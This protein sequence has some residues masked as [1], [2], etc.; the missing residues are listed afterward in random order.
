LTHIKDISVEELIAIPLNF[1]ESEEFQNNLRTKLTFQPLTKIGIENIDP[2]FQER[3]KVLSEAILSIYFDNEENIEYTESWNYTRKSLELLGESI[4]LEKPI[5]NDNEELIVNDSSPVLPAI[6]FKK[7]PSEDPKL[8]NAYEIKNEFLLSY[9]DETKVENDILVELKKEIEKNG[10]DFNSFLERFN[11]SL[12]REIF[13]ANDESFN[14]LPVINDF[15]FVKDNNS[16]DT[17]I[18]DKKTV[19]DKLIR[20]YFNERQNEIRTDSQQNLISLII[21]KLSDIQELEKKPRNVLEELFIN[22]IPQKISR[23]NIKQF[24]MNNDIFEDYIIWS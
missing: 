14:F 23:R 19:I 16:Y 9:S 17:F 11:N 20:F 5:I 7:I 8:D 15:T 18:S 21:N 4:I 6:C 10:F 24:L 22:L 13:S 2:I 3:K 1:L 12:N